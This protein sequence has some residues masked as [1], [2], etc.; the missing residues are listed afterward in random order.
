VQVVVSE[1]RVNLLYPIKRLEDTRDDA[2]H[3]GIIQ[4][5]LF[6]KPIEEITSRTIFHVHDRLFGP[7]V[8]L[9]IGHINQ[10]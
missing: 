6:F 2:L 1:I 4:V 5:A 9:D 8:I 7:I 3:G 10:G